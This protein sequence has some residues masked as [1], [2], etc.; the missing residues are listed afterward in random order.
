LS[1]QTQIEPPAASLP[2][3]V[4]EVVANSIVEGARGTVRGLAIGDRAPD[5]TLR[6]STGDPFQ[7]AERLESGPVVV[8]FLRGEWCPYCQ[9]EMR[10]L[11][12]AWPAIRALGAS[13]VCVQPRPME[14][15]RNLEE[16]FGY[17]V[18]AD[19]LMNVMAG[20][21]VKFPL[22]RALKSVY[23]DVFQLDL[24]KTNASGQWHLPVPGAFVVDV[25]G[26]VKARHFSHDFAV[27]V[28]PDY[29]L[30]ALGRLP[31]CSPELVV[32]GDRGR[33]GGD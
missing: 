3:E 15:A 24:E 2:H 22:P 19:D 33:S 13:L 25:D 5:F 10:A 7:L 29:L 30:E 11:H 4:I 32:A 12:D 17:E 26:I 27:R 28:S 1:E 31:E 23:L 16:A 9:A 18:L 14:V 21:H 6:G 20:F 8:C